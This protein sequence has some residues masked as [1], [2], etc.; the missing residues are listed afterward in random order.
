MHADAAKTRH[1]AVVALSNLNPL[2]QT[3]YDTLDIRNDRF[4]PSLF[5]PIQSMGR[6]PEQRGNDS[7]SRWKYRHLAAGI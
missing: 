7:L 4:G 6:A 3:L 2:N 1:A 5:S